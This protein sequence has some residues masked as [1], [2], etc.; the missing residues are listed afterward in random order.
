MGPWPVL[1]VDDDPAIH[2]VTRLALDGFTFK[3]RP[4]EWLSAHSAAEGRAIM[5]ARKDIALV[6]LDV[7]MESDQAG[8]ELASHIRGELHNR[9]TRIVVRT[10]EARQQPLAVIDQYEI[11]DFRAKTDLTFERMAILVKSSL[12][13]FDLLRGFDNALAT[14]TDQLRAAR[15]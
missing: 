15:A 10:G 6:L 3:S 11:D 1:I 5:A 7:V 13:T 4:L 9:I 12:R 14:C 2:T 8:L